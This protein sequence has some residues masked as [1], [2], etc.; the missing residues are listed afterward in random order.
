MSFLG[1]PKGTQISLGTC[2]DSTEENGFSF[3]VLSLISK[4]NIETDL[5]ERW[6]ASSLEFEVKKK[7]GRQTANL[8]NC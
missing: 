5:E 3:W 4:K 8:N 7:K 6:K 2:S 1:L